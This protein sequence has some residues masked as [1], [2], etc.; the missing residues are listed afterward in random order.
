MRHI[1]ARSI[2]TGDVP[3]IL[4]GL[5]IVNIWYRGQSIGLYRV[6]RV[7]ERAM[8]LKHGVISFPVGTPLDVVDFQRLIPNSIS[9][10]LSTTV[11]DN[12]RSGIRL[13]W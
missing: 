2:Q 10:R 5:P 8:V 13:A 12:N 6:K 11:V 9:P 1:S 3:S 4:A 7:D